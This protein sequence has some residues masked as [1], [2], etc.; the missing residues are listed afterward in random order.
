MYASNVSCGIRIV[1]TKGDKKYLYGKDSKMHNSSR[2]WN[3][4]LENI[5][6]NETYAGK[7]QMPIGKELLFN[8]LYFNQI[9]R[10]ELK[11]NILVRVTYQD[12]IDNWKKMYYYADYYYDHISSWNS[13]D[14]FGNVWFSMKLNKA[15]TNK[16]GERKI[17]NKNFRRYLALKDL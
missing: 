4:D 10:G 2:H 14:K 8:E 12:K 16:K 17:W 11:L 13:I 9:L 6:T 3:E 5:T 15:Y 1:I 7:E